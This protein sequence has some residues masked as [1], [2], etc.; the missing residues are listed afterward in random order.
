MKKTKKRKKRSAATAANSAAYANQ[1][2]I[3]YQNKEIT[4][5]LPAENFRGSQSF[6]F[7]CLTLQG[8]SI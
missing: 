4:S 5:K 8:N 3:A 2:G 1:G 6:I 7:S